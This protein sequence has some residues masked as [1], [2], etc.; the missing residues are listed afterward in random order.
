MKIYIETSISY[1]QIIYCEHTQKL[2]Q[3][4]VMNMNT[5]RVNDILICNQSNIMYVIGFRMKIIFEQCCQLTKYLK[6]G[7]VVVDFG[8]MLLRH[9]F[10][11]PHNVAALLLLQFQI[12]I[13]H[14]EVEL[15]QECVHVQSNLKLNRILIKFNHLESI[16]CELNVLRV[17]RTCLPKFYRRRCFR[18][19]RKELNTRRSIRQRL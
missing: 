13:E 17:R 3:L 8:S 2:N 6:N 15:L 11:D 16:Q 5:L 18:H 4:N 19:L 7:N 10:A 12:R 1:I 9:A 14:A